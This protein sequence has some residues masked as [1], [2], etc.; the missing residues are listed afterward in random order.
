MPRGLAILIAI[1]SLVVPAFA[2]DAAHQQLEAVPEPPSAEG[3]RP[4]ANEPTEADLL[5]TAGRRAFDE[6]HYDRA[7]DYFRRVQEL[8]GRGE[9]HYH[10]AVCADRLGQSAE[11]LAAYDRFLESG[12]GAVE[13]R[14]FAAR[15][16]SELRAAQPA[17][18]PESAETET[19]EEQRPRRPIPERRFEVLAPTLMI[20]VGAFLAVGGTVLA[21]VGVTENDR[22]QGAPDGA[23]WAEYAPSYDLASA[24]GI[25]APIAISVAL[26]VMIGGI[27]WLVTG[28][29]PAPA[30]AEASSVSWGPGCV[31]WQF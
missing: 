28:S 22:L 15:R 18:E 3:D 5:F 7:L 26:G 4:E 21:V 10:V 24:A 31:R 2:Q 6:G 13:I 16:L 20:A 12:E 19:Q 9:L 1:S 25:G 17:E 8:T 23:R 29:T 11:A 27:A 14:R 30:Q